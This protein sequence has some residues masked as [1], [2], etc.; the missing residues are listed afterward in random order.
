VV[1]VWSISRASPVFGRFCGAIAS[2]PPVRLALHAG[3]SS[4]DFL[5]IFFGT[6]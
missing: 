2:F 5:G 1:F 3:H 4:F 6:V